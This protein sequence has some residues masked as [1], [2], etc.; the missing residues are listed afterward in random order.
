[1]DQPPTVVKIGSEDKPASAADIQAMQAELTAQAELRAA[2]V[3]HEQTVGRDGAY[4]ELDVAQLATTDLSNAKMI[5]LKAARIEISDPLE[6]SALKHLI[7]GQAM[8]QSNL[9]PVQKS[10][11]LFKMIILSG[12]QTTIDT[13]VDDFD[14]TVKDWT[15]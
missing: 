9:D 1:M 8:S 12:L 2:A 15:P 7:A 10:F 5:V 14:L 4:V 3:A 6:I 11:W 13:L